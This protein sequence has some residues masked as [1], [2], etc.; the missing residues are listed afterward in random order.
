MIIIL[1]KCWS[2]IKKE[3]V[4]VKSSFSARWRQNVQV[5]YCRNKS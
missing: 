5:H 3:R 4:L 1:W 2:V